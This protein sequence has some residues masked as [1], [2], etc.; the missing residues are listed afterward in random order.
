MQLLYLLSFPK[1]ILQAAVEVDE[2]DAAEAEEVVQGEAAVAEADAVVEEA[3][4]WLRLRLVWL[5]LSSLLWKWPEAEAAVA[6][7]DDF[8]AVT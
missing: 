3:E 6:E 4:K 8:V 1:S 5:R 7:A 2:A